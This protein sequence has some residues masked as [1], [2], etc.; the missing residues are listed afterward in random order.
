MLTI[1]LVLY[2]IG[3]IVCYNVLLNIIRLNTFKRKSL[4]IAASIFSWLFL[5]ILYVISKIYEFDK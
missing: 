5:I 1:F 2:F 4:A 3:T